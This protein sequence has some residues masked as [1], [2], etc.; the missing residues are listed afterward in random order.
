MSYPNEADAAIN[1]IGQVI[2]AVVI[3]VIAGLGLAATF[4]FKL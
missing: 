2:I 3:L 1:A 4:F